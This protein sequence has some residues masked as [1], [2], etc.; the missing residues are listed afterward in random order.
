MDPLTQLLLQRQMA[1]PPQQ[2]AGPVPSVPPNPSTK[3]PQ[4]D[5]RFANAQQLQDAYREGWAPNPMLLRLK[6]GHR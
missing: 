2:E 1:Q 6:L 5:K 3:V 4:K